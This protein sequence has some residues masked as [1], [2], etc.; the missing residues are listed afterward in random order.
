MQCSDCSWNTSALLKY[1]I[2][3]SPKRMIS[4]QGVDGVAVSMVAFQAI[5]PGSTPGLRNSI[6]NPPKIMS[7]T[8]NTSLALIESGKLTIYSTRKQTVAQRTIKLADYA[9]AISVRTFRR[10]LYDRKSRDSKGLDIVPLSKRSNSNE[11]D[12]E[13]QP[14]T[15]GRQGI[16]TRLT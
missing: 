11:A 8:T 4:Y 10:E 15:A 12:H 13:P 6:L 5:D 7:H 3:R 2:N 16:A 9:N 1:F 14:R